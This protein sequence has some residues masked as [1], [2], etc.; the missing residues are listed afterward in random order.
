[1]I[2]P[3]T[4]SMKVRKT[5]IVTTLYLAAEKRKDNRTYSKFKPVKSIK[6]HSTKHNIKIWHCVITGLTAGHFLGKPKEH[7]NKPTKFQ[8]LF[9]FFSSK[10]STFS[11]WLPKKMRENKRH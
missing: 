1:M 4:V 5:K 2:N 10:F 3:G 11:V 7:V 9:Y 8:L 6:L